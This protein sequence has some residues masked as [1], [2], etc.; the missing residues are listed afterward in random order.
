MG[1]RVAAHFTSAGAARLQASSI[2]KR[3]SSAAFNN[4]ARS[5]SVMVSACDAVATGSTRI[6]T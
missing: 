4:V 1:A 5:A 6:L 2:W 3:R